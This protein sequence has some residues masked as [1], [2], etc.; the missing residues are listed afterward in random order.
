MIKFWGRKVEVKMTS[1]WNRLFPI[2]GYTMPYPTT[3]VAPTAQGLLY[4]PD[5]MMSV[6]QA[7]KS[8]KFPVEA[9]ITLQSREPV[10]RIAREGYGLQ[11]T[12]NWRGTFVGSSA[13]QIWL[14]WTAALYPDS[15]RLDTHP[16]DIDFN[17]FPLCEMDDACHGRFPERQTIPVLIDRSVQPLVDKLAH[18]W[19]DMWWGQEHRR[20]LTTQAIGRSRD[21]P[22]LMTVASPKRGLGG[23][24]FLEERWSV[25]RENLVLGQ[26][27]R[28]K[29]SYYGY[30]GTERHDILEIQFCPMDTLQTSTLR[31]P[32][33]SLTQA[34]W[35]EL[36]MPGNGTR[37]PVEPPY[38]LLW[39][40]FQQMSRVMT[41]RLD[42]SAGVGEQYDDNEKLTRKQQK[43]QL[44]MR[45][46]HDIKRV[47]DKDRWIQDLLDEPNYV[48]LMSRISGQPLLSSRPD[49]LEQVNSSWIQEWFSLQEDEK[50]TRM[51]FIK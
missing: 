36:V 49:R 22:G 7:S 46:R 32:G 33:R 6:E 18:Q 20:G 25:S 44:M 1:Y 14:D 5:P 41:N 13:F 26:T 47:G 51:N 12:D 42:P 35:V 16:Q 43:V 40:W 48:R 45:W 21:A 34:P 15:V 11:Q 3:D 50:K 29:L 38:Q 4:L 8:P 30:T 28:Y 31:T 19:A 23:I 37:L 17:W 9:T 27:G 10:W 24:P 2:L 39:N